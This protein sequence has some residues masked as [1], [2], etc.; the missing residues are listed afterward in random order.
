MTSFFD[1]GIDRIFKKMSKSLNNYVAIDEEPDEMFG[2]IM[3]ISDDLM[4]RYFDLLSFKSS[5]EIKE[6]KKKTEQG[7]NPMEAKKCLLRKL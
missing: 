6:L 5:V 1:T 3:S 4:W 7:L 2:K